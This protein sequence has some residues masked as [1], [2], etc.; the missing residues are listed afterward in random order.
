MVLR[1]VVGLG[2]ILLMLIG[3]GLILGVHFLKGT[4]PD[5]TGSEQVSYLGSSVQ[6]DRDEHAIP[7]ISART[8]A[9]AYTAL[10]FVHAQE[11]LFQM[12]LT[13]RIGQGRLSEVFGKKTFLLDA[14][15]RTIGFARIADLMWQK[16]SPKTK[17][18]LTAYSN[19]VN[20]F[21]ENHRSNLSFEFDALKLTPEKWRPQDC[22]LIGRLMAWE[23]NFSYWNDAAFGDIALAIDSTHLRALFPDYPEDGTTIIEGLGA[24]E[25][26]PQ[27]PTKPTTPNGA[28]A[29]TGAVT[30]TPANGTN[31][32]RT[33][34]PRQTPAASSPST[35]TPAPAVPR[36]ATPRPAQPRPIPRTGYNQRQIMQQYFAGLRVLDSAVSSFTGMHANGGGSNAIALAGSRTT[37]GGAML[38][39]DMH[40]ALS[41]PSRW[42]LAHVRS[43][44]GLN[45]AG[46]TVPGL[47]A[48]I[49][50][51]NES[52][53]WGVTNGMAD[54]SD[55][56]IE[57]LD[58]T[59][60]KYITAQGPQK[61]TEIIDSIRIK[62]SAGINPPFS[63]PLQ[64]RFTVHGPVISDI[65]PFRIAQ[66]LYNTARAGAIPTDTTHFE[67]ANPMT[68]TW[69]GAYAMTDEI[70]CFF[71]LHKSN[72][73]SDA[74]LSMRAFATPC[75]NLSLADASGSIAYQ[76]IGRLPKRSGSEDRVL[77]PRDG[78]DHAQEWEGFLTLADLPSTVNPPRGYIV[79]ANNPAV[80]NRA[81][82]F[83]N[84]WEPEARA[85]RISQLIEMR[86]K[87][88]TA[89]LKSIALD[90]TSP[91][92]RD[93][94][95]PKL[96]ALFP[97]PHPTEIKPDSSSMYTLDSMRH[98]WKRD[99][100]RHTSLPDT[101][102]K[103]LTEKDSLASLH[104]HAV[105]TTKYPKL[106]NL[107]EEALEYLR[108]WDGGMREE[109][110]APTIYSIFLQ[111]VLANTFRDEL[112]EQHFRE[113]IYIANV[114]L[115]TLGRLLK[116]STNIW[117]DDVTTRGPIPETRDSI[118]RLSFQ[119]SLR[120]L[121]KTFGNNLV[122][123]QWGKLHTLTFHHQFESGG[124]KIA[125]LVNI[126]G[127]PMSGGP[128]TVMQASYYLWQPYEM[129]VGPSMRM[130]ADMRTRSLYAALPTGN[131][132]AIF[133]DHYKDMVDMFKKGDLIEVPL[134]DTRSNWRRYEL[135]PK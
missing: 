91:F 107:T 105:D 10:G 90:V 50:G 97:D 25:M 119:Q 44:E 41:T 42:F 39:N 101:L 99:S 100:I 126:D 58:S 18:L 102:I 1:F 125:R 21:I 34:A 77:L 68:L 80:R 17:Q 79:S 81:V 94:L 110:I 40:L 130:I 104:L 46:F 49:S 16:T 29:K 38:E 84:N 32:N 6:I 23:M 57:K 63:V 112:G 55:F 129:K 96:L 98:A 15:S 87:L 133:S 28:K 61:F 82:P 132:A 124:S 26:N 22:L 127:G 135:L 88:D 36:P 72:S 33:P 86:S 67:H 66:M 103:Q 71:D 123:W 51:R 47:P 64:I 62:D 122:L 113:F 9:D 59:H 2:I 53:S 35:S 111:Q 76:F 69:N 78:S 93:L 4:I 114:P 27:A 14:W 31:A 89:A 118:L 45:V 48:F 95:L 24:A 30:T 60:T 116:D 7:H 121:S 54:E 56:F 75:L 83:G 106:D 11:R 92:D 117:W 13:R 65:H 74:R 85:E 108:N 8:D 120:I 5:Y 109:E 20:D 134:N 12:E 131:S 37:T 73:I 19:G 43:D 3:G 128:T 115:R 52:I 70:G